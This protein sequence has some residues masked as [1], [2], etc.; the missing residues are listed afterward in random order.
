M[1]KTNNFEPKITSISINDKNEYDIYIEQE[2]KTIHL[3]DA[4]NLSN[5]MPLIVAI[6]EEEKGNRGEIFVNGNLNE[7]FRPYFRKS[8][9]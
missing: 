9:D 7:K 1:L 3:G 6:I 2:Q 8:L 4:T 5:K